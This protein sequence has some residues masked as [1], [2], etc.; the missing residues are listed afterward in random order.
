MR[1]SEKFPFETPL[2][3]A[4]EEDETTLAAIDE[5]VADAANGKVVPSEQ[6][7][8]RLAKWIPDSSRRKER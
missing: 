6:V 2:P 4:S 5:G 7:R 8:K 3:E 1:E